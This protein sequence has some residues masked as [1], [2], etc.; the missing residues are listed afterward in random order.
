MIRI[1]PRCARSALNA[2]RVF[3]LKDFST[4]HGLRSST[5]KPPQRNFSKV[6]DSAVTE[7]YFDEIFEGHTVGVDG[8]DPL[9][10][11]RIFLYPDSEDKNI[12]ML[13]RANSVFEVFDCINETENLS[14]RHITQAL[15]TI[16][17]LQKVYLHRIF[18]MRAEQN[19]R[20]SKYSQLILRDE[21]FQDLLLKAEELLAQSSMREISFA[22]MALSKIGLPLTHPLVQKLYLRL[23]NNA[24]TLDLEQLSYMAVSMKIRKL[25]SYKAESMGFAGFEQIGTLKYGLLPIIPRLCEL[26]NSCA[27]PLELKRIAIC[28]THLS[29]LVSDRVMDRLRDK[30]LSFV[31]AGKFKGLEEISTLIKLL[32]LALSNTAWHNANP[33][34]LQV[35]LELHSGK[36]ANLQPFHTYM[37]SKIMLRV[38]AKN[39]LHQEVYERLCEMMVR[40]NHTAGNPSDVGGVSIM[41][42]LSL[43]LQVNNVAI[44]TLEAEKKLRGCLESEH[45]VGEIG[46]VYIIIKFAVTDL[47]LIDLFFE[48]TLAIVEGNDNKVNEIKNLGLGL[49]RMANIN[50]GFYN[51]EKAKQ[52]IIQLLTQNIRNSYNNWDFAEHLGLLLSLEAEIPDDV[53]EKFYCLLPQFN[54]LSLMEISIGVNGCLRRQNRARHGLKNRSKQDSSYVL[55]DEISLAVM[56][57][58]LSM[59]SD[60]YKQ[61]KPDEISA[62]FR[63]YSTLNA[64][65][66]ESHYRLVSDAVLKALTDFENFHLQNVGAMLILGT[67]LLEFPEVADKLLDQVYDITKD[68]AYNKRMLARLLLFCHRTNHKPKQQML[69]GFAESLC[70]DIDSSNGLRVISQAVALCGFNFLP[71]YLAKEIFSSE[72]MTKL[73]AEINTKAKQNPFYV[74]Q[75]RQR[76]MVLNRCCILQFPQYKVPWFHEDYCQNN[77]E[78]LNIPVSKKFKEEVYD[79]L[80]GAMGGW[81]YVRDSAFSKYFNHVH[82]EIGCD[83]AGNPLDMHS[84]DQVEP[85]TRIAVM[86]YD[87]TNYTQ[88]TKSL[89]GNLV[90]NNVHLDLQG[91][92]VFTIN[93]ASWNSMYLSNSP[94]RKQFLQETVQAMSN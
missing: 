78:V 14:P 56:K 5:S 25:N 53:I 68:E 44:P 81:R 73:D 92:Q 88:D 89:M 62:L 38:G 23:V 13:S 2:S 83:A 69:N 59:I 18:E 93:P 12:Q 21:G 46:A 79:E 8:Q 41:A 48:K 4:V 20:V 58:T 29:N 63:N 16:L 34:Y 86:A 74:R 61:L 33:K 71:E 51:N 85:A 6:K 45:L 55:L 80:C 64:P 90:L 50:N 3:S 52:R 47:S 40:A 22:F 42:L 82:F 1:L 37:L 39:N 27:T 35:L 65:F 66:D 54:A 75:L 43:V 26:L 17:H 91:W 84:A 30:F 70:H 31:E 10:D 11:L 57:A 24:Q 49:A 32:V 7:L 36:V 67:P 28:M 76:L 19:E 94:A 60:P 15:A 87:D 72:F 9:F 77:K